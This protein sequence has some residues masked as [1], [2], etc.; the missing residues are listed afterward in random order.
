VG[1]DSKMAGRG[2][3]FALDKPQANLQKRR[4]GA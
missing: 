3:F 4:P 2:L 1:L